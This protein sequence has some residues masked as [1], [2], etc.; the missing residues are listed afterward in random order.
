MLNINANRSAVGFGKV[1][2][3]KK[4]VVDGQEVTDKKQITLVIN[5]LKDV[6]LKNSANKNGTT[7]RKKYADKDP[8]YVLPKKAITREQNLSNIKNIILEDNISDGLLKDIE[9][10]SRVPKD[11]PLVDHIVNPG[12]KYIATGKHAK[13][14][15]SAKQIAS[16]YHKGYQDGSID[17]KT[18]QN[19]IDKSIAYLN[20]LVSTPVN[21]L[22]SREGLVIHAK[23][24]KEGLQVTG[25][26]F[27]A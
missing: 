21:N 20:K 22:K 11:V 15:Y 4:V 1:V 14:F 3:V 10:T 25:I 27:T 13:D 23:T 24:G 19:A 7:I 9:I 5:N 17:E 26:D 16:A 2:E 8:D 12:L 6:L 18:A